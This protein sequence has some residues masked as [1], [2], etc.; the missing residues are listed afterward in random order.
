MATEIT[1]SGKCMRSST[2]GFFMSQSVSP[3][4]ASLS[5]MTAQMSPA[6]SVSISSRLSACIC[7]R[8][9]IRSFLLE[10]ALSTVV[11]ESTLPL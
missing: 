5:P 4:R 6:Y 1:G 8:R 3:V 7:M 11:P 10:V 9:P 2:T